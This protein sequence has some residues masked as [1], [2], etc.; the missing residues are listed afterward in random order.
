MQHKLFLIVLFI[1][2]AI[3]L[4]QAVPET[5][6]RMTRIVG[7]ETARSGEWPWMVALVKQ[8][9]S[10]LEGQFCGGSLIHPK[11]VITAAHCVNESISH[12]DFDVVIGV[13]NLRSDEGKR[14]LIKRIILHPNYHLLD[15]DIAL[16]ELETAVA[17]KPVNLIQ[18]GSLLDTE[19]Q[20]GTVLGWGNTSDIKIRP[21]FFDELRE[22]TLPII[23]N[24]TCDEANDIFPITSNMLCAGLAEGGK[25]ACQGDSG[26]PLVVKDEQHGF[27]QVGIVSYGESCAQPN[28]YGVYTRLSA[29]HEFIT[30]HL[31][32]LER[33]VM[34]LSLEN[35]QIKM[36][37]SQVQGATGYEI[38]YAPYPFG[39][40][41]NYLDVVNQTT[42]STELQTGN[43]FYVAV[44]AYNSL[45]KSDFSNSDFFV[46]P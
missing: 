15:S 1:L 7:G 3:P 32:E 22:V 26:G 16:L 42:F 12:P 17:Q 29:F 45:C 8:K 10:I 9:M 39:L 28:T 41:I 21:A 36:S 31:C 24:E 2:W 5:E 33:P 25:D 35:K 13:H 18:P 44:K 6:N 4:A 34:A 14:V 19:G 40:P 38:Y 37:W 30:A 23:S 11:W 20:M 27:T 43:D 46:I